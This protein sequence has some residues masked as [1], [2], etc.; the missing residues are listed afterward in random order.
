MRRK[1]GNGIL[2][3]IG[4]WDVITFRH[5]QATS[6]KCGRK[7]LSLRIPL[8]G[9]S[10]GLRSWASILYVCSS[11]MFSGRVTRRASSPGFPSSWTL[12]RPTEYPRCSCSWMTAGV[13]VTHQEYSRSLFRDSI[14]LYGAKTPASEYFG[15][16]GSGCLYAQDT[17]AIVNVLEAYVT[18]IV[19]TFKDDS[20]IFAGI[21]TMSWA[22][23]RIRT[24]TG[25]ALSRCSRMCSAGH[26]R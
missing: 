13:R 23:D 26:V 18:D 7:I 2:N 15:P 20:R 22:A 21:S 16:C 25:S 24:V 9:N 10:A 11:I 5:M 8:T 1:P 12:P 19:S 17:T 4:L 6:W 14:I 3:G